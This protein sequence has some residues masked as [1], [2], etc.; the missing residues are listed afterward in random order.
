MKNFSR[1]VK[2]ILVLLA[3]AMFYSLLPLAALYLKKDPAPYTNAAATERLKA[4]K[5]AHF[6]FIVLSDNH[7]GLFLDD[8]ATLKLIRRVNRESRFKKI[9]VDMVISAGDITFRGSAWDYRMFNRIRSLIRYPM[10]ATMGNHD[11][12]NKGKER[13]KRYVGSPEFSFADRNSYFILLNNEE[14]DLRPPQ[15]KWFEEELK[16]GAAYTHRFVILHKAPLSPYQQS[17]HRPELNPWSYRFM[18]MCEQHKVDVVFS[19]HEHIFKESAYG[20]YGGVRYV[21]ASGAGI[22]QH[23][24]ASD[25]GFLHYVVVRVY[26]DYIDYEVRKVFPPLWEY[27]AFYFWKEVFYLAKDIFY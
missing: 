14:G 6:A 26:G 16:K 21:T 19:G 24:P 17:W 25:G 13:F 9:P 7:A 10:I 20:N 18:K 8:S 2:I 3:A 5:G 12:D 15:F 23:L 4:N 27:C 1:F 22:V 11:S